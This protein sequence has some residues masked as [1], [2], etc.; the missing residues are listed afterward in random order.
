MTAGMAT[1]SPTT[2]V[3]RAS[4]TPGATAPMFE[5]PLEVIPRKVF[6]IPITVPISPRSGDTDPI[7]ASQFRPWASTSRSSASSFSNTMRRA[8]S[9]VMVSPSPRG[10]SAFSAPGRSS[11]KKFTPWRKTLP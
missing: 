6:M 2:V 8:C 11:L 7:M 4:A 3:M 5:E 9:W 10:A 1:A